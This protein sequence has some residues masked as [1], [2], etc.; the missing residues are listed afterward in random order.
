MALMTYESTPLSVELPSLRVENGAVVNGAS[1]TFQAD[2]AYQ[3]A[4]L[5]DFCNEC[6]NCVTSCPTSGEPYRDKPRLYLDRDDF[7]AQQDN[8]FMMMRDGDV[9]VMEGRWAGETHRIEL[10]GDLSYTSPSMTARIDPSDFSVTEARPGPAAVDGDA[11]SL[12]PAASMY[13]LLRGVAGSMPQIPW[14]TMP[15]APKPAGMIAH[16][17]YEE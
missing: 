7:A 13:V 11:P 16:P 5:T 6:G 9:Q 14:A 1:T 4:V 8:A 10:N 15:G 2:Q 17:G 3:I 12:Q